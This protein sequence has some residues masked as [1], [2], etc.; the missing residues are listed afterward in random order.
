MQ[1]ENK[2]ARS[3]PRR[4]RRSRPAAPSPPAV[5]CRG[6]STAA[7]RC[8]RRDTN[9]L[10]GYRLDDLSQAWEYKAA[11]GATLDDFRPCGEKLRL[12]EDRR[13][14]G[15]GGGA[16]HRRRQGPLDQAD[17]CDEPN[18]YVLD[19]KLFM[20][21]GG[22][23]SVQEPVLLDPANGNDQK[24]IGGAL[25]SKIASAG[26]GGRVVMLTIRNSGTKSIPVSLGRRRRRQRCRRRRLQP[27]LQPVRRV[28][29]SADLRRRIAA[30]RRGEPECRSTGFGSPRQRN[31]ELPAAASIRAGRRCAR[32]W[33]VRS[34]DGPPRFGV[35]GAAR[36]RWSS[37]PGSRCATM[38]RSRSRVVT[39]LYAAGA[40]APDP[41]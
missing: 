25:L 4:R 20:G 8:S 18:W 38:A 31:V 3:T 14:Q 15:L 1:A 29:A 30:D 13:Q 9:T 41:V 11:T 12:R 28:T 6:P 37:R 7:W 21:S 39:R 36:G 2:V 10:V 16:Q 34:G 23:T 17:G 27:R 33:Q 22:F 40:A 35:V 32:G 26:A 19:G 5:T 24:A